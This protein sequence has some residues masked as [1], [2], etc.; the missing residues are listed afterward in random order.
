LADSTSIKVVASD[1]PF[2]AP[3]KHTGYP[4]GAVDY[5]NIAKAAEIRER[6]KIKLK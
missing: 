5:W 4:V 6:T 2:I 3:V 1:L